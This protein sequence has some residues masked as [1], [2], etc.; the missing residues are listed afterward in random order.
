MNFDEDQ[1]LDRGKIVQRHKRLAA[2]QARILPAMSARRTAHLELRP[3]DRS[4]Q[5]SPPTP[6]P[7]STSSPT[8][9]RQ[10]PT[11]P[12]KPSPLSNSIHLP[13]ELSPPWPWSPAETQLIRAGYQPAFKPPTPATPPS[14]PEATT[15]KKRARKPKPVMAEPR[16]RAARHKGQMNFSSE[17]KHFLEESHTKET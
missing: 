6:I 12:S 5:Q 3:P 14:E 8:P 17:R 10:V 4:Q 15:S 7:N 9:P 11:P 13:I 2:I 1:E 16:A